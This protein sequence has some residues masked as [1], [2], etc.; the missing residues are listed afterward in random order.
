M[1]WRVLDFAAAEERPLPH[2]STLRRRFRRITLP[3]RLNSAIAAAAIKWL[4]VAVI[5]L[6]AGE[7]KNAVAAHCRRVS[8]GR[9]RDDDDERDDQTHER[10]L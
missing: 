3:V 8:E 1:W 4:R 10:L 6:L 7:F 5:T 9:K 2:H